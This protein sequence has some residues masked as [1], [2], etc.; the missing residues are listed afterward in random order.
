MIEIYEKDHQND[1]SYYSFWGIF[2]TWKGCPP[3]PPTVP[4]LLPTLSFLD[5]AVLIITA[6]GLARLFVVNN[7]TFKLHVEVMVDKF[8]LLSAQFLCIIG[9]F[10]PPLDFQLCLLCVP[11]V[12]L[13]FSWL[14]LCVRN[15]NRQLTMFLTSRAPGPQIPTGLNSSQYISYVNIAG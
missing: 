10:Y 11:D 15:V 3:T 14:N 9:L 6:V 8:V 1:Y 2:M 13:H 5:I 4:V 7:L 12:Y